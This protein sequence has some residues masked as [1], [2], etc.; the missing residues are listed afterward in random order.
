MRAAFYRVA[1]AAIGSCGFRRAILR[2]RLLIRAVGHSGGTENEF[3]HDLRE[4]FSGDV[5]EARLQDNE[6]A[7]GVAPERAGDSV[8]ADGI[9]VGGLFAVED[10]YFGGQGSSEA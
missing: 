2:K 4:G 9:G 6:T 7:A 1:V 10:L 5:G 3:A 8:D